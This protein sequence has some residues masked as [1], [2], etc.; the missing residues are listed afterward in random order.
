MAAPR[1]RVP[2]L[3]RIPTSCIVSSARELEYLK[4]RSPA[5]HSARLPRY[6]QTGSPGLVFF[7][8]NYPPGT[9]KACMRARVRPCA[10]AL[11]ARFARAGPSVIHVFSIPFRVWYGLVVYVLFLVVSPSAYQI[12]E[13]R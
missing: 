4:I 1:V 10:A 12:C 3:P 5:P 8:D 6:G 11:V 7:R 2:A 13:S 9:H